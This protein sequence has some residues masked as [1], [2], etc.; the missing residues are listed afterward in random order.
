MSEGGPASWKVVPRDG[1][2]VAL[3]ELVELDR[4]DNPGTRWSASDTIRASVHERL[5]RRKGDD[6]G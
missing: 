2:N 3:A 5:R 1:D 6:V 4:F